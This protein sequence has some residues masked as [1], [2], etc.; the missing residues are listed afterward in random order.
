MEN[1][2][3][4]LQVVNE[5]LTDGLEVV[6]V[7]DSEINQAFSLVEDHKTGDKFSAV[8]PDGVHPRETFDHPFMYRVTR[9]GKEVVNFGTQGGIIE[10]REDYRGVEPD[11]EGLGSE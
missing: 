4:H 3:E 1:I 8:A 11:M 5:R 9:M 10:E 2:P 7:W 6:M